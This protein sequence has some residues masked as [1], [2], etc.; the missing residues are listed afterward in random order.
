MRTDRDVGRLIILGI[1]KRVL[2]DIA[3]E[4]QTDKFGLSDKS[5]VNLMH[6]GAVAQPTESK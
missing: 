3:A 4:S 1:Y 5:K 2:R 6:H